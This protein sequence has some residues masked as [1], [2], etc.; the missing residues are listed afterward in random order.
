MISDAIVHIVTPNTMSGVVLFNYMVLWYIII[1]IDIVMYI[2]L[3]GKNHGKTMQSQSDHA[4]PV[5]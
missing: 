1:F 5:T 4:W 3:V 2:Y